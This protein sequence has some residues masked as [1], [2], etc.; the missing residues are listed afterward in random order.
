MF[1]PDKLREHRMLSDIIFICGGLAV[2]ALA[3]LAVRGAE[4]L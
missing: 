3:G 1:P 2:F 4:R